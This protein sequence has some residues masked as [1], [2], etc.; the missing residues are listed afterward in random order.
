MYGSLICA[1]D[2]AFFPLPKMSGNLRSKPR[3]KYK[4]AVGGHGMRPNVIS[5]DNRLPPKRGGGIDSNKNRRRPPPLVR[6]P[7]QS[8]VEITGLQQQHAVDFINYL[9]K[10]ISNDLTILETSWHGP[11]FRLKF[12]EPH[13]ATA[14][15]NIQRQNNGQ[16]SFQGD[17]INVRYYKPKV[18]FSTIVRRTPQASS[19]LPMLTALVKSRYNVSTKFLDL[20]A[21]DK[22]KEFQASTCRGFREN[23]KH[24]KFGAVLCKLIQ[25]I[26]PE[27]ETISFAN[28]RISSLE[29]FSTLPERVPRVVNL[30]FQNNNLNSYKD[31]EHLGASS[32]SNLREL[33]LLDNPIREKELGK[34]GDPIFY[35][36][37]IKKI[38]P[39]ITILDM[40]PVQNVDLNINPSKTIPLVSAGFVDS[41]ITSSTSAQFLEAYYS[42]FDSGDR[43]SLSAYYADNA[44]FSL[45]INLVHSGIGKNINPQS[46]SNKEMFK[47]FIE[48]DHNLD[49]NKSKD[50]RKDHIFS[51]ETDI[52]KALTKLPRTIHPIHENPEKNLFVMD[53]YQQTFGS[54]AYLFIHVNGEFTGETCFF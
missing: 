4:T 47:G 25:E 43:S 33:V 44:T 20:S 23:P 53:A 30:S 48:V 7:E 36:S 26:C 54:S 10:S 6:L 27:V 18:S 52:I 38:F 29:F 35:A 14:V 5:E 34:T 1:V 11:I 19:F 3:P 31:L 51:G 50:L 8:T 49:R 22:E 9:Q 32:L 16:I 17:S 13:E 40:E 12:S 39:T 21:I 2:T 45:S 15:Y 24:T 41:D 28:N 46:K 37:M 42:L